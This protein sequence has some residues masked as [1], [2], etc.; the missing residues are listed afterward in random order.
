MSNGVFGPAA[1]SSSVFSSR[2]GSSKLIG[3]NDSQWGDRNATHRFFF[4]FL[5]KSSLLIPRRWQRWSGHPNV[6]QELPGAA[7]GERLHRELLPQAEEGATASRRCPIGPLGLRH[8]FAAPARP[9]ASSGCRLPT[10]R[11]DS[12]PAGPPPQ[13]PTAFQP[14]A[15]ALAPGQ[16]QG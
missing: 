12:W 6:T 11:H 16:G 9:C 7:P 3:S 1:W 8:A 5:N 13:R 14:P 15:R 10:S 4:F 2:R